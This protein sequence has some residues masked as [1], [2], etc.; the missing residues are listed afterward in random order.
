MERIFQ[1]E[2]TL[3]PVIMLTQSA[4]RYGDCLAMKS[5]WHNTGKLA[6]HLAGE[7]SN[8]CISAPSHRNP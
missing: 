4:M 7:I 2:R 1:K 8:C 6:K 3:M 5:T